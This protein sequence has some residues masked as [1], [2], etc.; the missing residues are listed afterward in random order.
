MEKDKPTTLAAALLLGCI[1][2]FAILAQPIMT[3][4]LVGNLGMSPKNAGL[5]TALEALGTALG[6]VSALLWMPRVGRRTAA[7]FALAVVIA[8][9]ILS[10]Y[11]TSFEALAVLRLAVGLLG[12]GTAFALAMTIVAGTT[13]KDRNFALLVAA[14]VVLGVL[15]FLLLPM[16]R[17]AGV[18]GVLLPMLALAVAGLLTV[19]W[20]PQAAPGGAQQAAAA[21]TGAS[22]APGLYA[23]GIMLVWCTGLG[24][25]WAFVK[26]IGKAGGIPPADVGQALALST[27]IATLGA[28]A[29]AAIGDRFGRL[30]PVSVALLMQL[31]MVALLRGEMSWLQFAATAATFQ[32]FWN[33]TG[34]YLMGTVA[35]SDSTGRLSLLIPTAQIGGFFLGPVIVSRFLTGGS[36][37]PANYV[38]TVCFVAALLL[39]VPAAIRLRGVK[40]APAH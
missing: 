9:N 19:G 37:L 34:P 15:A 36:L 20:I 6:P 5:I 7:I 26:L 29:A 16:P 21:G 30:A 39:F 10:S 28:L 3:E 22:A 32:V 40:G 35:L 1:G 23:L 12:Q 13:Q 27:A 25:M 24:A 31:A 17:G 18:P 8:G 38:A 4:A 11:Q 2:V 33:L 14:Q